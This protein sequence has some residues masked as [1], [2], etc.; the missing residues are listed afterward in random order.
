MTKTKTN[1]LSRVLGFGLLVLMFT[2][3][4]LTPLTAKAA[5]LPGY[6]GAPCPVGTGRVRVANKCVCTPDGFN[7]GA[8]KDTDNKYVACN[9]NF[10]RLDKECVRLNVLDKINDVFWEVYNRGFWPSYRP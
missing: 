3:M 8:C 9:A 7:Y 4:L 6:G 1:L 5:P 2:T 10:Y